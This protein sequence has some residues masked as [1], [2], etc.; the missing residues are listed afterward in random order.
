MALIRGGM[1]VVITLIAGVGTLI[2]LIMGGQAGSLQG[3]MSLSEFVEFNGYMVALAFP[4]T[5]LGW[6]FSVWHQGSGS[7]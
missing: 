2:V 3:Q 5:A 7:V 4:T 6:V 1:D